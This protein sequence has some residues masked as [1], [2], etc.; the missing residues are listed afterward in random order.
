MKKIILSSIL[1]TSFTYALEYEQVL[2]IYK[3]G[4]YGESL[5]MSKELLK[6]YPMDINTNLILANSA[7][8]LGNF[9]EAI[10]AYDR[11]I[12]LA[13]ENVFARLQVAEIYAI[14]SNLKLLKLEI[15]ALEKMS[16]SKEEQQKLANLKQKLDKKEIQERKNIYALVGVGIMFDSNVDSDIGNRSFHVPGLGFNLN[17]AK[18]D[19]DY[20]HFENA[21]FYGILHGKT[22][23]QLALEAVVNLYNKDYFDS[24]NHDDD[25]TLLSLKIAPV[26]FGGDFRVS[27]PVR[28]EKVLLDYKSYVDSYGIGL[29]ARKYLDW[30][31]VNLGA[32]Y[33]Y[34]SYNNSNKDKD[35][36]EANFYIKASKIGQSYQISSKL[37]FDMVKEKKDIRN[38]ISYNKFSLDLNL[39]K[40]LYTNLMGRVGLQASR[41]DYKDYNRFFQNKREDTALRYSTGVDYSFGHSNVALGVDFLDKD[42]NEPIYEYDRLT[43][44]LGYT[45]S[46]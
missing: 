26:Y 11:V 16:L 46:F 29:D 23:E 24:K 5:A 20:A 28:V 45:Y 19:S 1:L 22:Y 30:G 35:S 3:N 31:F 9:H 4:E 36:Q 21:Y 39:Y 40:K 12:I 44:M 6:S 27:V 10:A 38:D 37:G 13:P 15:D 42:S 18:E 41:Y 25:A 8:T 43:V 17:G 34:N 7:F 2:E 33:K 32:E 14:T